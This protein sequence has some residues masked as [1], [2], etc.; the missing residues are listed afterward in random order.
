MFARSATAKDHGFLALTD[1]SCGPLT[2]PLHVKEALTPLH[3]KML[4][5]VYAVAHERH[6]LVVEIQLIS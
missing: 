2:K 3:V 6:G 5:P 1:L 4:L